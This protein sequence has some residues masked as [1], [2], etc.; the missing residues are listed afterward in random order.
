MR[1][2]TALLASMLGGSGLLHLLRPQTYEAIVPAWVPGTRRQVVLVSGVAEL[3]VGA[4]LLSPR[5]R[6]VAA[7]SAAALFVVVFPANVRSFTASPTR[8]LRTITGVRLPLQLPLIAW[9]VAEARARP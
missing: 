1:T 8:T 7:W 3:V 6:S 4:T 2:S 5:W 9:A